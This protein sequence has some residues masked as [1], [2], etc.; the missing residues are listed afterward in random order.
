MRKAAPPPLPSPSPFV[1]EQ[2]VVKC[3]LDI[4]K[5]DPDCLYDFALPV[6]GV[7]ESGIDRDFEL[8]AAYK[9]LSNSAW[10]Q[11][12]QKI[13]IDFTP[14]DYTPRASTLDAL[15][16]PFPSSHVSHP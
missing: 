12:P 10:G 7:E 3:M 2:S 1:V 4:G 14:D 16:A 13:V 11:L 9:E 8:W 15:C 5:T 6:T